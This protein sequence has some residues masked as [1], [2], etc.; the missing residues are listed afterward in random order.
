MTHKEVGTFK[1]LW[2]SAKQKFE[3]VSLDDWN[4]PQY[5]EKH[6]DQENIEF[7]SYSTAL[8]WMREEYLSE[9][10]YEGPVGIIKQ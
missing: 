2:N 8:R 7:H 4:R 10:V 9:F 3:V 6:P 1:V 5:K